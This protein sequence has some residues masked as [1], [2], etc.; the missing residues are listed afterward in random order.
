[1]KPES[2]TP[3]PE[4]STA[5][6]GMTEQRNQESIDD[7]VRATLYH[8]L[9]VRAQ[10]FKFCHA[11]VMFEPKSFLDRCSWNDAVKHSIR[12]GLSDTDEV[13]LVSYQTST[14]A[15]EPLAGG[16]ETFDFVL[17]PDTLKILHS[18]IGTWRS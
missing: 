8:D 2:D 9:A 5:W 6:S 1:M 14:R 7:A 12:D 15:P 10:Q 18:S 4:R 13:T 16:G 17:H 3:L 11:V